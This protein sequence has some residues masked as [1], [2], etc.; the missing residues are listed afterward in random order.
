[1][2]LVPRPRRYL[3]RYPNNNSRNQ[4]SMIWPQGYRHC[5]F[6]SLVNGS[7]GH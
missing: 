4:D 5:K 1:L 7:H 6:P 2:P 3:Q